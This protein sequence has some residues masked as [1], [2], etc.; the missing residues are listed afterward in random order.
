MLCEKPAS[1]FEWC[2]QRE[3]WFN[4]RDACS[5]YLRELSLSGTT[6][7]DCR[8]CT[9]ALLLPWLHI[10]SIGS[11]C[12]G[13]FT[14]LKKHLKVKKSDI[15]GFGLFAKKKIRKGS[16]LGTCKVK[17]RRKKSDSLY[18]LW[19][20]DE[21]QRVDVRGKLKYINHSKSPNVAYYDDLTVVA[22]KKI[23]PGEELVH[24]YG[25]GWD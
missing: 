11:N 14:A 23:F 2:L 21:Q 9:I 8:D 20:Q 16:V 25:E 10:D 3:S 19:I 22:L 12:P 6:V 15:H 18:T 1:G 7:A 4:F 24:D 5:P 13:R 17:P